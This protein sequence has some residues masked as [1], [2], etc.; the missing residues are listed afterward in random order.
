MNTAFNFKTAKEQIDLESYLASLGHY[1]SSKKGSDIWYVS[2]FH[3]E[4][5]PSFKIDSRH[6]IWYDHSMGVGG[7]LVDFGIK[8]HGCSYAELLQK[9]KDFLSFQ[10]QQSQ[11]IE[12]KRS[13]GNTGKASTEDARKLII[14]DERPI[15]KYYLKSYLSERCIPLDLAKVYLSEVDFINK[16]AKDPNKVY[17]TLGFKNDKGGYE[18]RSKNFKGSSMPKATTF[19]SNLPG[20]ISKTIPNKEQSI[21][22]IEGSFSFLSF[23]VLWFHNKLDTPLPDN[24]LIL[25]SLS[26]FRKS[27]E[28]ME[29]FGATMLFLDNDP[30]G[31]SA[32]AEALERKKNYIDYST[33][34]GNHDDLNKLL[35]SYYEPKL[36]PDKTGMAIR[37]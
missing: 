32:T 23:K 5:T 33:C 3:E 10:P 1:P 8:Y 19:I 30:R 4:R 2:P 34:C 28:F 25:N 20:E 16:S 18:L 22:V 31:K 27:F 17:T 12:R 6:Q 37:R 11:L 13:D 14:T 15:F 29:G 7:D 21:A 9:F 26:F 35:I 24:F 36:D